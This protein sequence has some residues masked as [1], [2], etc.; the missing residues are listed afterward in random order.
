MCSVPTA[1]PNPDLL[2]GLSG[3]YVPLKP[4]P[5]EPALFVR[6][7]GAGR[8]PLPILPS[9][10]ASPGRAACRAAAP[11][12]SSRARALP[13]LL[14][15]GCVPG[16]RSRLAALDPTV[17]SVRFAHLRSGPPSYD[18]EGGTGAGHPATSAITGSISEPNMKSVS[19]LGQKGETTNTQ[20]SVGKQNGL[21]LFT[22][23]FL[24]YRPSGI[25][26]SY[27][28]SPPLETTHH[29]HWDLF[30]RTVVILNRGPSTLGP[31]FP[32]GRPF[33]PGTVHARGRFPGQLSFGAGRDGTRRHATPG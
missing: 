26:G 19:S 29:P 18:A 17:H 16:G 5:P 23:F 15:A 32:D 3:P 12:Y 21:I 27:V 30:S 9:M 13:V 2:L 25:W 24:N 22:E 31:V 14:V 28:D 8:L 7:R 4:A 6:F 1:R 20:T 10:P 33:Q 11:P